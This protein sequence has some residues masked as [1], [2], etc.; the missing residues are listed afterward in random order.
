[1]VSCLTTMKRITVCIL[2]HTSGYI[3][4]DV[5]GY[6]NQ[7]IVV[8]YSITMVIYSITMVIYSLLWYI[9]ALF[10]RIVYRQITM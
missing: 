5:A 2:Y 6:I 10:H 7:A 9:L 4:Q 3:N 8:Q 1:M